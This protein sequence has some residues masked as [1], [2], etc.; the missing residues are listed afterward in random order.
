MDRCEYLYCSI[1]LNIDD[2]ATRTMLLAVLKFTYKLHQKYGSFL[3]ERRQ[4]VYAVALKYNWGRV[5]HGWTM[6]LD[7]G[8]VCVSVSYEELLIKYV[9]WD[10]IEEIPYEEL[11]EIVD[12]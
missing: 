2:A 8:C 9:G 5:N 1:N 10:S 6:Y 4:Q 11:M 12:R 7:L 3:I